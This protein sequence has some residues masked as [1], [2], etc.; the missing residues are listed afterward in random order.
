MDVKV[1]KRVVSSINLVLRHVLYETA[2][3]AAPRTASRT[4]INAAAA[5][6]ETN[7]TLGV[8]AQPRETPRVPGLSFIRRGV[9]G[10][11]NAVPAETTTMSGSAPSACRSSRSLATSLSRFMGRARDNGTKQNSYGG[12]TARNTSV[13]NACS[14]TANSGS[15]RELTQLNPSATIETPLVPTTSTVDS[16]RQ[17]HGLFSEIN[18]GTKGLINWALCLMQR[19]D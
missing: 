11:K 7:S 6:N 2:A 5:S 14:T 1:S 9:M 19:N 17:S 12:V 10:R 4:N 8:A 3:S 16:K 13:S 18:F 15:K